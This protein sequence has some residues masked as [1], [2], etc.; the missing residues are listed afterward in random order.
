MAHFTA[1]AP[2]SRSISRSIFNSLANKTP[3]YLNFPFSEKQLPPTTRR[4]QSTV[5]RQRTIIPDVEA[6]TLIVTASHSPANCP[7][8]TGA[9][10]EA[11]QQP[12]VSS[13]GCVLFHGSHRVQVGAEPA[14]VEKGRPNNSNP[15]EKKASEL[16]ASGTGLIARGQ[17]SITQS[18]TDKKHQQVDVL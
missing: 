1:D 14:E 9:P 6:L 11:S 8:A 17:G 16:L 13:S 10:V 15:V 12:L 7:T 3:R 4:E 18:K 5:F 2:T